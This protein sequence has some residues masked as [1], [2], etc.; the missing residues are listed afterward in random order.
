M[1][2]IVFD[3]AHRKKHFTFF[4]HMNH[5]HFN[6]TANVEVT[7]FYADVKAQNLPLTY[8]LV[9]LLSKAANDIKEFRW[10]IRDGEVVEHNLVHPSFTVQTNEADVFSFCTVPFI[11]HAQ[12]FLA[13]AKRINEAMKT[14]P[15]IEDEP[16]RDDYLFMSAIPWVSFTSIQHAMHYHPHDSVP[17]ISWGKFFDQNGHRM[18]PLSVQAHHALV[19]GKHMGRYFENIQQILNNSDILSP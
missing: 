1:K 19:D 10:R 8:S 7:Q 18:M 2:K 11:N 17:R 13:E 9:F 12:D 5:P 14:N 4:N 15:S 3:N 6:I 16:G